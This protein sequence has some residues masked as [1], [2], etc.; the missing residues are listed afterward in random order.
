MSLVQII[1]LDS[2]DSHKAS[3]TPEPSSSSNVVISNE[4]DSSVGDYT[5][6]SKV[7]FV[8]KGGGKRGNA[9]DLEHIS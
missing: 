6:D 9:W 2:K 7:R 5:K 1:S 4:D 8:Q 3:I